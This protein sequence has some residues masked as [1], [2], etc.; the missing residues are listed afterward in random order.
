MS[1]TMPFSSRRSARKAART[2]K[3]APCNSC[4]GPNTAPRKEC[5]IMIWPDTSTA[6]TGTSTLSTSCRIADQRAARVARRREQARQPSGQLVEVDGRRQ[7]GVERRIVEQRDRGGKPA[8]RR[9][10]R[11]MRRRDL[12]DLACHKPQPPAVKRLAERRRDVARPV[13]AQLDDGGL[14]SRELERCRETGGAAARMKHEIAIVGRGVRR[15]KAGAER[16]RQ[17]GAGRRNIDD[18]DLA[19]RNA[20]P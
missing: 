15:R 18:S 5:A 11:P 9:P 13:P 2:R 1:T 4:A 10:A 16:A 8:P 12:A 3:V 14:L 20:R 17:L 7:Q 6:N 19:T